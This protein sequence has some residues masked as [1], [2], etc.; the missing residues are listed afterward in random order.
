MTT[1][2][3]IELNRG[4]DRRTQQRSFF[5]RLVRALIS[6]LLPII[7]IAAGAAGAYWFI[8]TSPGMPERPPRAMAAL[9]TVIDVTPTTEQVTVEAMGTVVP[10]RETVIMPQV[11]GQ[12][13]N[14]SPEFMI[15]GRFNRDDVLLGIEKRD[16]ELALE[17]RR[18]EVARAEYDVK[19]EEGQQIIA[20]SELKATGL[21]VEAGASRDLML[22]KPHLK[23]VRAALAAARANLEKAQLD[24][25]RTVIRSP[26][27]AVVTQQH[28][29]LGTQATPQTKL[30]TLVGTDAYWVKVSLP[31]EKL[32]WVQVPRRIGETGSA[33]R[34]RQTGLGPEDVRAG[35]V[36]RSLADMETQG[37]LAN[38]LVEVRD[39]LDLE[40]DGP[41][42]PPLLLGAYV[43]V[44]MDGRTL[45]NVVAVPRRAVREGNRVWIMTPE[46]TLEI[47]DVDIVWR[48]RERALVA[49][50][51]SDGERVVTSAIPTPVHGMRLRTAKGPRAGAPETAPEPMK[52]GARTTPSAKGTHP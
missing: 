40:R 2:E 11:S 28:V 34:V 37:R 17:G 15:G 13:V 27:N 7:I 38:L 44:T 26:F 4:E 9:V 16:Y 48:D 50:G 30:V 19:V 41:A 23:R 12:I 21:E 29:D 3:E 8:F 14:L 36:L 32:A 33:V 25:D 5:G 43:H 24:L 31:V 45:R 22:R 52:E 46:E 20:R 6:G 1:T 49:G 10:A 39:P 18:S 42:R 47:R 51:L 35:H